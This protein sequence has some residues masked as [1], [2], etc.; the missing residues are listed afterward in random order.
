MLQGGMSKISALTAFGHSS[1]KL[2]VNGRSKKTVISKPELQIFSK[3]GDKVKGAPSDG[4]FS[5]FVQNCLNI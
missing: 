4:D 5:V 1:V 2:T 3:D